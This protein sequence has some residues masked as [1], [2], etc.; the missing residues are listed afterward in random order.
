MQ[1]QKKEPLHECFA[2]ARVAL[3]YIIIFGLLSNLLML[4][5]PIYSLQV[6][7][8]VLSS[9]NTDTLLMLTLIVI[10]MLV[11]LTM[12]QSARAAVTQ[13]VA[14]WL[15]QKLAPQ[16]F[17][18]AVAK[19]AQVKPLNASQELRDLA[20]IRQFVSGQTFA[21]IM[22]APWSLIFAA[23]LFMLHPAIGFLTMAGAGILVTIAIYEEKT[24][25]SVM[26]ESSRMSMKS[27]AQL[28]MATRN[29]E[30]AEAMGMIP[31]LLQQWHRQYDQALTLSTAAQKRASGLG[32]LSR[33]IRFVLQI[34]IIG[35]GAWL[36]L[37]NEIT[38][39][40]IIA[41]SILVGRAIAPLEGIIAGW[42]Q[43]MSVREAFHRLNRSL[44]E[45]TGGRSEGTILPAP[46]GRLEG[47]GL[48]YV[49]PGAT[50]PV[51]RNVSF[52]IEPGEAL[53]VV[54]PSGAGKSTLIKLLTGVWKPTIG[55]VRLDGAEIRYWNR[56]QFG[57]H[58]GYV[59]QDV[60]LFAGTI[61]QNIARMDDNADDAM[62]VEAAQI[63]GVHEMILQM[64]Q[65][66]ETEIGVGGAVLSGGQRQRVALA[67]AVFG[68]P[69][70]LILDEPNASLDSDGEKALMQ[71]IEWAKQ[72]RITV[73][74]VSHRQSLMQLADNILMLNQ[75]EVASLRTRD[76]MF[77]KLKPGP[78][79]VKS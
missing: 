14:G 69:S 33:F 72:N 27:Y 47:T 19:A 35:T 45:D 49:P 5:V 62:V 23:M 30:A 48:A 3:R 70:V 6:L 73:V 46:L 20:M 76:D 54:G 42:S 13:K 53:G 57:R 10:S 31:N 71:A 21:A 15:D 60:E 22:D 61:W 39:G 64:P 66:Y 65:G 68:R 18:K 75:G 55:T 37:H 2:A 41:G 16:L 12:L 78:R 38:S 51:L 29:A 32:S 24:V 11:A 58:V 52:R 1:Q 63:A 25:K 7:D 59:P 36:A 43:C 9:G 26:E 74:M 50:K 79:V 4:A 77:S 67:R 17:T 28:E 44:Q 8:R 40:A 56:E 34:L